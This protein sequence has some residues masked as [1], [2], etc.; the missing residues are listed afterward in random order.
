MNCATVGARPFAR[1]GEKVKQEAQR[2]GGG[3]HQ[4]LMQEIPNIWAEVVELRRKMKW[5]GFNFK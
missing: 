2:E 1:E 5:G 4:T 3:T